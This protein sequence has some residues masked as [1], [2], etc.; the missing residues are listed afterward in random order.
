MKKNRLPIPAKITASLMFAVAIT[1]VA[2]A[3]STHVAYIVPA[4]T[5]GNQ[6]FGGSLGLDFDASKTVKI[7]KLGCFD[8]L[9]NGLLV[10][11]SVR[12]YNRETLE[13]VASAEF[14]PDDPGTAG[15]EDG[16]LQGGNRFLP[17]ATPL[18][19]P[20]GFQGSIV[21][22]GYGGTER[23]GNRQPAP[24]TTDN[25][26]LSLAFVGTA[27]YKFPIEAGAWPDTPDGGPVARYAAGTFE[28]QTTAPPVPGTPVPS[29]AMGNGRIDLSWPVVTGTAAA[30][31]YRILRSDTPDGVFTQIAQIPGT[32]YAATGLTNGTLHCYK[33]VAVAANGQLGAESVVVCAIPVDLGGAGRVV[34]YDTPWGTAGNQDFGGSLGM[35]F[36]TVQFV[37]IRQLGCFDDNSD[38]L[39][40]PITVK[41]WDRDTTQEL[42]SIVFDPDD[43][44]TP[45]REDGKQVGGMRFKPLPAGLVLP[46]GFHG[47]IVASG[48][49][50]TERNGNR[51][52]PTPWNLRDGDGAIAFVG[53]SAYGTAD[54]YPGTADGGPAARYGA[55]TFIFEKTPTEKP[56]PPVAKSSPGKARVDLSWAGVTLPS[57]AE[58]YRI[59][60]SP[61][62]DGVFTQV[63][64]VTGTSYADTGLTNGT[65]YCY[66]VMSLGVGG[67]TGFESA[68]TCARPVDLG[69][70]RLVAYDTPYGV[71][72]NQDF[73]GSLGMSFDVINPVI[74]R[75]LGCFDDK[76]D[77]LFSG[78]T[79]QMWNRDTQ[80]EVASMVLTPGDAGA[81]VGGMRFKALPTPLNLPA[82]F[83]GVISASGYSAME[84]NGNRPVLPPWSLQ[85]GNG[86][87]AFTGR[88]T[89]GDAGT[90]PANGDVALA[91]YGAGTF[92]YETTTPS[93]PGIPNVTLIR[94]NHAVRLSWNAVLLPLPAAS[95]TIYRADSEAGPFVIVGTSTTP[96]YTDSGLEN[97]VP[98]CYY[99]V[100]KA[101]GGQIGQPSSIGCATPVARTAGIAY[102]VPEAT[103]GN[104]NFG[105]ALGMEF[106]VDRPIFITRLGAFDSGGDGIMLPISV[107][108]Y[109]RSNAQLLATLT[110]TPGNDGEL[111]GGSRFKNLPA[112]IALAA[113]FQGMIVAS[114]YG[115]SEQNGNLGVGAAE[116]GLT[117]FDGGCLSFVGG[118]L[119]STNPAGIADVRDGGP[120]NRYAAGTFAFEPDLPPT[121]LTIQR[122]PNGTVRLDW[123][124]ATGVLEGTPNVS[125][126][127]WQVVPGAS[128]LTVPGNLPKEFFRLTR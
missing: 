7:T 10:P 28:Y 62:P 22:E 127:P 110:F 37:V 108:L 65:L 18:D 25:G 8:D 95:Y 77:G 111:T 98:K 42:A 5:A 63:A 68:I 83:R 59:L 94:E 115:P 79:I 75:Q 48:Y 84:R 67:I 118:S 86:S 45:E 55:G 92:I 51:G 58:S 43:A 116:L 101:A 107:R 30:A 46:A 4:N 16:V 33:V 49:N 15:R 29:A 57:P 126:G 78:I 72:G 3:Q 38:G 11:I 52:A 39:F 96:G 103:T 36:D 109:N 2:G 40:T 61:S 53:T 112:P 119:Y 100:A 85:D 24:W 81:P 73:G 1:G 27:R 114:G 124:D 35:S 64:V 44:A 34:A 23:N 13:V 26:N 74:I 20:A 82:G 80:Q 125:A 91:Q 121:G 19:L 93:F 88:S 32:S 122:N 17:L 41:L 69:A 89:N 60:R 76:S 70:N 56:G 47:M 14:L 71:P 97:T 113:G 102:L 54:A 21:A 104:Q 50:G 9:S 123:T 6:A 106:N 105:G 99:V 12:L 120:A 87:I 128:G 90:F 31:N 66:K 117:V